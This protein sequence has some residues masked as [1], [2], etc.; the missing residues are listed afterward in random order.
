MNFQEEIKKSVKQHV[1]NVSHGKPVVITRTEV[2]EKVLLNVA[3]SGALAAIEAISNLNQVTFDQNGSFGVD[4]TYTQM[5]N[6]H[7]IVLSAIRK[8][9]TEA[10][11]NA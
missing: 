3:L 5:A 6:D 8:L 9:L 7:Q 2:L 4:T 1:D 11:P 10:S